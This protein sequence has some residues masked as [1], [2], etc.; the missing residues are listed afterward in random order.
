MQA[1]SDAALPIGRLFAAARPIS[2]FLVSCSALRSWLQPAN[3]PP[4]LQLGARNHPQSRVDAFPAHMP[5]ADAVLD[6]AHRYTEFGCYFV[7]R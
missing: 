6:G 4:A 1:A 2:V 7:Q 5:G 3:R